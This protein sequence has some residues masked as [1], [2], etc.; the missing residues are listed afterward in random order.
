MK[1]TL[2]SVLTMLLVMVMAFTVVSPVIGF[3]AESETLGNASHASNDNNAQVTPDSSYDAGWLL[4]ERVGNEVI[5]TLTPDVDSLM[6]IDK[7][8]VKEI[9]KEVFNLA[10]D[11]VVEDIKNDIANGQYGDG[12]DGYDQD[13]TLDSIW[14]DA[15]EGYLNDHRYD[16]YVDF[17]KAAIKDESV[18]DE[19][20]A[21]ACGL[22][23]TAYQMEFV[24]IEQLEAYETQIAGAIESVFASVEE[25]VTE[26]LEEKKEEYV[27][28]YIAWIFGDDEVVVPDEIKAAA[29]VEL[30][31]YVYGVA[32]NAYYQTGTVGESKIEVL[33]STY[34]LYEKLYNGKALSEIITK[35]NAVSVLRELLVSYDDAEGIEEIKDLVESK[36][37]DVEDYEDRAYLA[38]LGLTSAEVDAKLDAYI[39]LIVDEYHNTVADLEDV[40]KELSLFD[41]V[42][43]I[44]AVA[45]NGNVLYGASEDGSGKTV[46]L[47]AAVA[48]VKDIP[49]FYEISN[50]ED[51]EMQLSFDIA[52]TTLYGE[53]NLTLTGKVGGGHDEVRKVAAIISEF[54]DISVKP[55]GTIDLD[56]T[57][58]AKFSQLILRAAES[59]NIDPALKQKVFSAFMADGNDIYAFYQNFTF[60]DIMTLVRSIDF[61]ALLDSE[62]LAQ[63]VDL[64]GLTNEQIAAKV[65]AFRGYFVKAMYYVDKVVNKVVNRIPDKYMDNDVLSL[66]DYIEYENGTFGYE[67]T[68]TLPFE[69]IEKALYKVSDKIGPIGPIDSIADVI[70]VLID[71]KY[72][73][74]GLTLSVDI[75]IDVRQ[76]NKV[77]Y[78]VDGKVIR[79]GFLPT[80]ADVA[81]FS[82]YPAAKVWISEDRKVVT[83]MPDRD[84]TLT[85]VYEEG[86]YPTEDINKVYDGKAEYVGVYVYDADPS[87]TYTYAW[88]KD[89]KLVTTRNAFTVVDVLDSGAYTYVASCGDIEYTGTVNVNITPAKIEVDSVALD[90]TYF[91]FDGEEHSVN[92]VGV[93]EKLEIVNISG[94]TSASEIGDYTV[95]VTLASTDPNYAPAKKNVKLSWMI[96]RVIDASKLEWTYD[97]D[98]NYPEVYDGTEK[99]VSLVLGQYADIVDVAYTNAVKVNAGKYVAKATVTVK[100]DLDNADEYA[101]VNKVSD[102]TWRIFEKNIDLSNFEWVY[103]NE[104]YVYDGTAKSVSLQLKDGADAA[105]LSCVNVVLGGNAYVEAGNYVAHADI[106]PVNSN[107][108]LTGSVEDLEWSIKQSVVSDYEWSYTG[109]ITYDGQ[110][111]TVTITNLPDYVKATYYVNS[112]VNAGKYTAIAELE[113][114]D[115]NYVLEESVV[116]FEWEIAPKEI[117]VTDIA[118]N[119][120]DAITYD[121]QE[122]TINYTV[123]FADAALGQLVSVAPKAGSVFSATAVGNYKAELDFIVDDNHTVVL[124]DGVKT[125]LDWSIAKIVLNLS[126]L[127]WNYSAPFVYSENTE[128]V[129]GLVGVDE[130]VFNV[131]YTGNKATSAGNYTA[132][133]V[134]TVVDAYADT[135]EIVGTLAALDWTVE[136]AVID[137]TGITLDDQVVTYD[138]VAHSIVV[139]ADAA[140][141]DKIN[142]V[143]NGN[144]KLLC[145]SY[146]VTATISL[147]DEYKDNYSLEQFTLTANLKITGDK[148][149]THQI[150]DGNTVLVQVDVEGGLSPDTSIRGGIVKTESVYELSNGKKAVILVAYDIEFVQAGEVVDVDGKNFTVKLLIPEENRDMRAKKLKVVYIDGNGNAQVIEATRDG[151]YMVFNTDHFSIY[152]V[153]QVKSG[154]GW[155]WIVLSVLLLAGVAVVVLLVLKKKEEDAN[156]PDEIPEVPVEEQPEEATE[157]ETV[158][159]EVEA[160]EETEVPEVEEVVEVEEETETPAVE[161]E[162]VVEE[163]APANQGVVILIGE[164]KDEATVVIGGQTVHVRFRSSFMSRLIQSSEDIQTFYTAIKNQL[165]SYKGVK[166]RSSWNYEAFNKGRVQCAK[167]NIK[168]KTL[169]INLNLDP[170]EFNINKYHFIDC[171]S[172]PKYAK[173]PMMMK[174]RSERALKYTLELIDAMMQKLEIPQLEMPTEDY[175][176]PYETTESLARRGLVKVI[177]PTGITVSEDMT[178]VHA[179][180]TELIES[181]T[182]EKTTEQILG[183]EDEVVEEVVETPVVEEPVVEEPV[184]EEPVVEEPVV[185]EPVVEEPVVEEPVVEEP[186]VEEPVV[187]EPVVEEP[188]AE[189]P[190]VEATGEMH[191]DADTADELV[192][193]EEAEANIE[194][195]HTGASERSGKMGEINLD[196]ICENYENDEIVNVD[197]LKERRL[198]SP[199]IARVKVL[200]RG[201]MTKRLT[202]VASKFS[203]Q[204]VKMI[205]LAGGKA[206]LED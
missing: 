139:K 67:G 41:L 115:P 153:A 156:A 84:I 51:D 177:L 90:N 119:Y 17:F 163:E 68:H 7:T 169:I 121:A 50:M 158:E 202:V 23:R 181:G 105:L 66:L 130:S 138:G 89:G 159:E 128:F 131:T 13:D 76:I 112:A 71:D 35:A 92:V 107:Y 203:I 70:L 132:S 154:L 44:S 148:V 22:L 36:V 142:V 193:D 4:I 184:V 103:D 204:A 155:L 25:Q 168:G 179:N 29:N 60:D 2:R 85:A 59:D 120:T 196:T 144:N 152:A 195:V 185:E 124:A 31:N 122:H 74:E 39:D 91:N 104:S 187:E 166:V 150:V 58:P 113:S 1:K 106:T 135:H 10:K 19:F 133:A 114:T 125:T 176:M 78:V 11:M 88:Y 95:T 93:P 165:L 143:Y 45:V 192:S 40:D 42:T 147:K 199:K 111:H 201:V 20:A 8:V 24:T 200:A 174:V 57:V 183:S 86:A 164:G 64:S 129:V 172:K 118:W 37:A 55:D 190:V 63:Y 149:V 34:V 157:E 15:I 56:I 38:V 205:T 75:D 47:G 81:F 186:V 140:V 97:N 108:V 62:F 99:S 180:V 28:N 173:V 127:Q 182:T 87:H 137:P 197:T 6:G 101:V 9:L 83:K 178:F 175:H 72:I 96:K 3:A 146:T 141:L 16:D 32:A 198:I 110:T 18:I 14:S 61:E 65:E 116:E 167:L 145:G 73:E 151:D 188:V 136:K 43:Y 160:V 27:A 54:I 206:E 100:T 49:N 53:C 102:K 171:T 189:E 80:G 46:D 134:V 69:Y 123:T 117:V 194:I 30:A 79:A 77:E 5:V 162:P 109:P 82:A 21:Y 12:S 94:T 161:E 52:I 33:L 191:V 48:L 170:A 98:N 26:L 126:D